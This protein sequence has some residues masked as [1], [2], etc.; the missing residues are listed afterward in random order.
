MEPRQRPEQTKKAQPK[1]KA[2]ERM[3]AAAGEA[4]A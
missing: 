3:A 4:A 2:Q 1:K